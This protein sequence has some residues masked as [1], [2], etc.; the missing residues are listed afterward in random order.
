MSR[1]NFSFH[2]QNSENVQINYF[3]HFS[4]FTSNNTKA[5]RICKRFF[6]FRAFIYRAIDL[7][8]IVIDEL[9]FRRATN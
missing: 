2:I 8:A 5:T 3:T 4:R 9:Q 6:F 7:R 1:R